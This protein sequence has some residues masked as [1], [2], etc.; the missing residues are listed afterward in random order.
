M[1]VHARA[2]GFETKR[3]VPAYERKP[4]GLVCRHE[5]TNAGTRRKGDGAEERRFSVGN[6]GVCLDFGL[7][8]GSLFSCT[9]SVNS[10]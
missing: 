9:N 8:G 1:E 4:E 7:A 6:K 3:P 5:G 2:Y 10:V